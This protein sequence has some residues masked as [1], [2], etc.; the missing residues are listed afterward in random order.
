MWTVC[1]PMAATCR[2]GDRTMNTARRIST[3]LY[4]AETMAA[5]ARGAGIPPHELPEMDAVEFKRR[6]DIQRTARS[7]VEAMV[8]R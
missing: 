3:K 8:M 7:F 1:R 5:L 2:W 6:R 4:V